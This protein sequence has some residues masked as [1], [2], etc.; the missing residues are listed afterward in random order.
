MK[1]ALLATLIPVLLLAAC[2]DD[3]DGGSAATTVADN[4]TAP[5][6]D[7]VTTTVAA[8]GETVTFTAEVW[9]DNWFSLYVNGELVGEDSVPITTERSF[10][11]DTITFTATYPL[12]IAMVTKDFKENDS[13][14]EYIGTDRQQMGD[15]GFIAQITDTSTGTV[16][17]STSSAWRGLVIHRAPLNTECASSADP[18][19]ECQYEITD[20]PADW[21]TASFDDSAWTAAVE[22]T[23]ADVGAKDGYDMISWSA[24]ATLIWSSD[25]KVDNT[26]L[27]RFVVAAP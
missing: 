6:A 26:V 4:T 18:T 16:V 13:G 22:Y 10:N 3:G 1:R 8:T 25:L 20:E 27:W 15:G 9:A 24:D 11:A 19:T 12:T 14:L 2:S 23:A 17:A 5:T 7:A 21:A